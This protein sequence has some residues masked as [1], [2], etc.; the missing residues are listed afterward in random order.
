MEFEQ[1]TRQT[2]FP[3]RGPGSDRRKSGISTLFYRGPRRRASKGRRGTDK[4]GYVD[5]YDSRTWGVA[6]S[7]LVLSLLDALLTGLQIWRGTVDEWNPIMKA[8]LSYGG[9]IPFFGVKAAMT[10]VA[11]SILVVHK[12]WN[13][14]RFA[15]RLCLWAYCVLALYHLYLIQMASTLS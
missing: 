7:I 9:M 15:A 1:D 12:E 8:V 2:G 6:I 5:F 11:L 4:G 14:A 13:L 10:A 3:D